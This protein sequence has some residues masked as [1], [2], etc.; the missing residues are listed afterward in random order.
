VISDKTYE[1]TTSNSAPAYTANATQSA[2]IQT[3][4]AVTESTKAATAPL[5][6][7]VSHAVPMPPLPPPAGHVLVRMLTVA[8]NPN[9]FK[10]ATYLPDPTA[11]AG[12]DYCGI[13][14][15]ASPGDA[16]YGCKEGDRI[17]GSVF[18][19]NRARPLDGSFA[20]FAIVDVRLALRIPAGWSDAQGAAMGGVGWTA[21]ALALWGDGTLAL[22]G[23]PSKPVAAAE[24]EPVLV[25]G[26][27]TASGTMASQLL[28]L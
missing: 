14:V 15:A 21:A 9:D 12:C 28:K 19:Y 2:I 25:Y 17:C 16:S 26:G 22:K 3:D 13:V 10:M 6:L 23:R 18:A 8:L 20:Q 11:T 5:S 4:V 7:T 1:M 27:A 24:S